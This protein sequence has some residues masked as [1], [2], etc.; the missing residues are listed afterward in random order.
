MLFLASQD[1]D[2]GFGCLACYLRKWDS[3]SRP[4]LLAAF[5]AAFHP[6]DG[7]PV[8]P[9]HLDRAA[10]WKGFCRLHE[11]YVWEKTFKHMHNH[12]FRKFLFQSGVDG[13]GMDN[14][15][16]QVKTADDPMMAYV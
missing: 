3:R 13:T 2:Q 4:E 8:L 10:N 7:T 11:F 15:S 16:C 14:V 12:C 5:I 6:T 9:G 1:V